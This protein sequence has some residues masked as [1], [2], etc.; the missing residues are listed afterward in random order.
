MSA[1]LALLGT[2]LLRNVVVHPCK[3]FFSTSLV[4]PTVRIK[5]LQLTQQQ[6]RPMLARTCRQS[7][8]P[9]VR[10][11]SA[12]QALTTAAARVSLASR[13]APFARTEPSATG[14]LQDL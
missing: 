11:L 6:L 14:V 2:Q 8:R 9:L 12:N 3:P 5:L 1:L 13:I 10:V 7:T 4:R